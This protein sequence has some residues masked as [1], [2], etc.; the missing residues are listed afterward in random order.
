[1]YFSG[2]CIPTNESLYIYDFI[3]IPFPY[4][5]AILATYTWYNELYID[6]FCGWKFAHTPYIGITLVYI[7]ELAVRARQLASAA[8]LVRG[9]HRNHRVTGSIGPFHLI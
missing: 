1:M 4:D 5:F 6:A 7:H 9:L 8:Q 2:S 3:Y